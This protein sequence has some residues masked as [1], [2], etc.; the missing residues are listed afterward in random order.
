M[1]RLSGAAV[2]F[3]STVIFLLP[4]AARAQ[5]PTDQATAPGRGAA[6]A[7]DR[8]RDAQVPVATESIDR[9]APVPVRAAW[10]KIGETDVDFK[11]SSTE[12]VVG[13]G[14]A[15][16]TAI[17][18]RVAGAPIQV[19][20]V[21]LVYDLGDHQSEL[22]NS[23][24]RADDRGAIIEL[25]SRVA[26]YPGLRVY[27][28]PNGECRCNDGY[29]CHKAGSSPAANCYGCGGN[30]CKDH[31]GFP[32]PPAGGT[33]GDR[34]LTGVRFAYSG[35]AAGGADSSRVEVWGRRSAPAVNVTR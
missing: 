7:Q 9:T 21:E 4:T 3:A 10:V 8:S 16:C 28:M 1:R 33:G 30:A 13:A 25:M 15:G 12:V 11:R 23:V 17:Q 18:F 24:V 29:V 35:E 2:L 19:R 34:N 22:L 27:I 6:V 20:E 26:E 31:G 32:V 14:A 5:E